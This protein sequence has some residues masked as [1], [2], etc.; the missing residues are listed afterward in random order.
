MNKGNTYYKQTDG[1]WFNPTTGA[2]LTHDYHFIRTGQKGQP[3]GGEGVSNQGES[4]VG[5]V[6]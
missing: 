4:S 5:G 6:A 1:T 3:S 2:R